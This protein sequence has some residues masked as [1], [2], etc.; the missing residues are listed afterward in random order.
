MAVNVSLPD[1]KQCRQRIHFALCTYSTRT[2]FVRLK[3]FLAPCDLPA[4]VS[5]ARTLKI[6][7]L[8]TVD[9][10][11]FTAEVTLTHKLLWRGALPFTHIPLQSFNYRRPVESHHP[12]GLQ[13]S[14]I[15]WYLPWENDQIIQHINK[16]GPYYLEKTIRYH[17][18]ESQSFAARLF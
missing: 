11:T 5:T 6:S 7:V 9:S 8:R 1:L 2:L 4:F 18:H 3:M 17:S 13:L 16:A 12:S 15:L 14:L 10:T